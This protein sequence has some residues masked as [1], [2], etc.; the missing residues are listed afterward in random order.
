MIEGLDRVLDN[1]DQPGVAELRSLLEDLL[2]GREAAGRLIEQETLQPPGLRM[3]RLR[4][5]LGE[6]IVAVVIKRLRPAIGR[7]T[8]LV[9]RRWL[10]AVDLSD[11]G[12][13]LMGSVADRSGRCV[14]HV[15]DDLGFHELNRC[16]DDREGIS[17]AVEL[18][19]SMHTRFAEHPLLG[20]VRL[21]GDDLGIRFYESN[22]NDAIYALQAC[23]GEAPHDRLR[24][25]L[26]K[27]LHTLQQELRPRAQMLDECGGPETLLHGDLWPINVFVIRT[28][29]GLRARL[30]DWDHTG[31]GPASYDLSTFLARLPRRHRSWVMN[32]YRECTA[33][34]GWSLPSTSELNVLFETAEYARMTNRIIWPAIAVVHDHASWGW[35]VLTEVDEW[36]EQL[37]P[38]LPLDL[39]TRRASLAQ[40]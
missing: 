10:P 26:L 40:P 18:I 29:G 4:F 20:E 17:A 37:Q 31:V 13:P 28:V 35:D 16:P 3:F 5:D 39:E 38:V 27:R 8:E 19:A 6:Q 9:A 21:H 33:R 32:M 24:D 14:W 1:S 36:F 25:R 12:P 22:V 2:G 34:A 7:R 11:S 23:H 30:I 15:Y